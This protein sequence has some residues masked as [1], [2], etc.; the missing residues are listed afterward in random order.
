M[1]APSHLLRRVKELG[2][3][4]SSDLVSPQGQRASGLVMMITEQL[5]LQS[6]PQTI[7]TGAWLHVHH[8]TSAGGASHLA[9]K[10]RLVPVVGDSGL[11]LVL[12]QGRLDVSLAGNRMAVQGQAAN[13]QSRDLA[14]L[15]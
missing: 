10:R 1:E 7:V 5:K 11:D 14:S 6:L 13:Q 9:G 12:L 8:C 4:S 3:R 2:G 15:D